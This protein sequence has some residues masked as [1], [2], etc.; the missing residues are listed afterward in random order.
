[1]FGNRK[2]IRELNGGNPWSPDEVSKAIGVAKTRNDFVYYLASARDFG[3]TIGTRDSDVISLEPLGRE[4]IY[5][6]TPEIEKQ[7]KLEA[8]FRVPLFKK[9]YEHYNGSSLP[10]MTYLAN[11]LESKFDI[12]SEFHEEFKEV[13]DLNRTELDIDEAMHIE[14]ESS[15]NGES[16]VQQIQL[17]SSSSGKKQSKGKKIF[18]AIPFSEKNLD[19]P[20]GFFEEV[21]KSLI[22]PAIEHAGFEAYTANTLLSKT[23]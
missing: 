11:T 5:A 18:V 12:P 20:E 4:I 16:T 2:K 23:F 7:K 15:E 8:F 22:T 13:Y 10:E 17:S 19:R 6:G 1:M 9:V 21:L 14:V 3:I